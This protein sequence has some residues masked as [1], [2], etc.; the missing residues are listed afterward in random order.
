MAR[1]FF[2][3]VWPGDGRK[4]KEDTSIKREGGRKG[5]SLIINILND[6]FLADLNSTNGK[7][8]KEGETTSEKRRRGGERGETTSSR[9]SSRI[10]FCSIPPPVRLEGAETEER[11]KRKG[12]RKKEKKKKTEEDEK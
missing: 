3:P 10:P 12:L 6:S 9:T 2:R 11:G 8:Y 4:K 1:L 7:N 5:H